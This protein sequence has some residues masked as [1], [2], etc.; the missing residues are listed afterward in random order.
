MM[1]IRFDGEGTLMFPR[2]GKF[3]ATWKLGKLVRGNYLFDDN[4]EF[5]QVHHST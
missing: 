3:V 5:K 1:I 2:G 4:L